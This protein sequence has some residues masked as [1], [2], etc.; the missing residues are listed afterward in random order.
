MRVLMVVV[1]VRGWGDFV[2]VTIFGCHAL[3]VM[4]EGFHWFFA[5]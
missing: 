4:L 3:A 1:E 5:N 2:S